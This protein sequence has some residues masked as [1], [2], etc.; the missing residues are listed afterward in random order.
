M[1]YSAPRANIDKEA[2]MEMKKNVGA[3]DRYVRFILGLGFFMNIFSLEPTRLGLF[4]LLLFALLLWNS[5][6]TGYCFIYDLLKIDTTGTKAQS[7]S[8]SEHTSAAH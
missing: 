2:I 8:S 7:A 3:S 4:F 1:A 6:Y 5:A